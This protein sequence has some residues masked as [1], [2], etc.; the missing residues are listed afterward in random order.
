MQEAINKLI[1]DQEA[2]LKRFSDNRDLLEMFIEKFPKDKSVVAFRES[3][4]SKDWNQIEIDVHTMKG[5]AGNMGFEALFQKT[6]ELVNAIRAKTFDEAEKL[7]P[8]VLDEM[9]NVVSIVEQIE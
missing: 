2:A 6:S 7:I 8:S 9:N 4:Q 3:S 5:V 1:P